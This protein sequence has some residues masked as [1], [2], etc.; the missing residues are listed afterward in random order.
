MIGRKYPPTLFELPF[1]SAPHSVEA[2]QFVTWEESKLE[3]LH[4]V[5]LFFR[6]IWLLC[7]AWICLI[8]YPAELVPKAWDRSLYIELAD[9]S[10]F[11][12][13]LHESQTV[14]GLIF[15][16]CLQNSAEILDLRSCSNAL[17]TKEACESRD[18]FHSDVQMSKQA[19][20][21]CIIALDIEAE[22]WSLVQS[23]V[24]EALVAKLGSAE[25]HGVAWIAESESGLVAAIATSLLQ[26][27]HKLAVVPGLPRQE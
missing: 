22:A 7:R 4:L 21:L 1:W 16:S 12:A 13:M 18:R 15:F 23:E 3:L 26:V 14:L 17:S 24:N 2:V 19:F 27:E 9:P 11:I 20:L 10:D 25:D 5:N 6:V 8:L